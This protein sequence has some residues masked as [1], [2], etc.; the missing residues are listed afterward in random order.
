MLNYDLRYCAVFG[1][2]LL[3]PSQRAR[4]VILW[5]GTLQ[6]LP[7]KII[8]NCIIER[9]YTGIYFQPCRQIYFSILA[10]VSKQRL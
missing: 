4:Q 2:L 3:D 9:N 5:K 1:S 10:E 7:L 8:L 6:R